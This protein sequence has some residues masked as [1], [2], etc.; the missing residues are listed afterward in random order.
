VL[1]AEA[2]KA[3]AFRLESGLERL[4]KLAVVHWHDAKAGLQLA[5]LDRRASQ[6]KVDRL[7]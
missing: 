2:L 4:R 7:F 1:G 5:H 6:F 3:L